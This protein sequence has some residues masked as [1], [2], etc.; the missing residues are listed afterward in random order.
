MHIHPTAVIEE[1]AHIGQD[2][3]IGPFCTVGP[4]VKIGEGTRLVSHVV[5]TGHTTLGVRNTVYPFASLGQ[6]SPDRKYKG[7]A[8][9]LTIGDENDIREYVTMHI[10]TDAD[11]GTTTVGSRNL[12]M[13]GAH[14]AH[15]CTVGDDCII[16]NYAQLAGHVDVA[17]NVVIGGL[18]GLHQRVRIGTHAIIGG[19]TAVEHD[20]PPYAS[21]SGKRASLKG[22]NLI[23]LRRRGF[24]R[25]LIDALDTAY[26]SLFDPE[27]N[28]HTLMQRAELLKQSASQEELKSLAE[29]VLKSQRG[30][31]GFEEE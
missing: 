24:E 21:V 29:F 31:T 13:A 10:G 9:T 20:V 14:V 3:T 18:S 25:N 6:P 5:I 1:G 23:G 2:V 19:H 8:C 17:D 22:L 7:E 4:H 30:L 15:D 27:D 12:L 11:R 28:K 16:A 26:E